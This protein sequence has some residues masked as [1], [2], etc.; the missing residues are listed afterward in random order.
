MNDEARC[1]CKISN[2]KGPDLSIKLEPILIQVIQTNSPPVANAGIDQSVMEGQTTTLDGSLSSDPDGNTLTY[3]WT[4][5]GGIILSATN[6]VKP[7]FT[8]PEVTKDTSYVVALVVNDGTSD[9][10]VDQVIIHIRQMNKIPIANAGEDLIIIEG[11]SATLDGSRS[12]DPDGNDLTYKWTTLDGITLSS[13]TNS[14]LPFKAPIISK[15][16]IYTFTLVVKDGTSISLPDQFKLTV[17]HINKAPIANAGKDQIINEGEIATLNGSLSSDLEKNTLTFQWTAP[18]GI[19]LSATNVVKPTFTAPEVSKDT[20][21]TFVLVVNDGTLN[22]P[23]DTVIFTVKQVNKEPVANAGLQ[24]IINEGETT[25]LDGSLSFDPDKNTL[26]YQWTAPAGIILSA[27]NEVK[28]TFT[29]PEVSKDTSYTFT[30]IVNDGTID[31]SPTQVIFTV[32]QV[33]KAPIANAG[34]NQTIIEGKTATLDGSLSFDPDGNALTF[35]WTAPYG[36]TLSSC[37]LSQPTFIAPEVA[38]DT[39]YTFI[40]EVNNGTLVSLRKTVYVTIKNI[41]NSYVFKAYPNPTT[42]IVTV[43]YTKN[44]NKKKEV[45]ISTIKC[46]E[47]MRREITDSSKFQVDLSGLVNGTY[48]LMIVDDNQQYSQIIILCKE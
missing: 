15:D 16:T 20:S 31:S 10:P 44:P 25:T 22:S 7:T 36:I 5:S 26:T 24:Y 43:E 33:P 37:T 14:K 42:G 21:Y 13:N 3:Q 47:V 39:T 38:K 27:T 34:S 45:L 23:S 6:V 48:L 17:K 40:L 18:T 9:S 8:A 2:A 12:F 4:A 29:A 32:K 28:P 35:Q 41:F 19:T 46:N 1:A 11:D 30:L